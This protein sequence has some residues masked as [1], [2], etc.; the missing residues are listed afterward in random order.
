MRKFRKEVGAGRAQEAGARPEEPADE[1]QE[2]DPDDVAMVALGVRKYSSWGA[3]GMG[4][5]ES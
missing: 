1:E 4:E 3:M 2:G 5:G